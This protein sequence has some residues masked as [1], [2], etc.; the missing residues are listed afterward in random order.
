MNI[1]S[2]FNLTKQINNHIINLPHK[3]KFNLLDI[4]PI[5]K[6]YQGND[7]DNYIYNN[8]KLNKIY[9]SNFNNYLKIPIKFNELSNYNK[10]EYEMF[11]L[12]WYPQSYTALHS[13]TE[14]G[15]LMKIL[16]GNI[17]EQ[18]IS[19]QGTFPQKNELYKNDISYIHNLEGLHRIIN[20]NFKYAYSLHIYS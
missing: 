18:R 16:D 13:H 12:V 6:A 5:L 2:L 10:Y 1:L 17:I 4:K 15:C 20:N 3:E 8:N 11:L 9:L 14:N 7:W 19:N